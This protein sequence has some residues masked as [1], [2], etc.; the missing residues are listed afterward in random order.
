MPP[1][2]IP[3]GKSSEKKYSFEKAPD[4]KSVSI[5]DRKLLTVPSFKSNLDG[6]YFCLSVATPSL[7][8]MNLGFL[9]VRDASGLGRNSASL[10]Q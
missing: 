7:R 4:P 8:N 2:L 1:T 10:Q 5:T 6:N 9:L 3:D